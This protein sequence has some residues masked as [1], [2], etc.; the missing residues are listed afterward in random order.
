MRG[1]L[2]PDGSQAVVLAPTGAQQA[3][4]R[5]VPEQSVLEQEL[6]R[7]GERRPLALVDDL[8]RAQPVEDIAGRGGVIV[9][10]ADETGHG[11]VPEHAADDGGALRERPLLRWKRV[12]ACLQHTLQRR[13]HSRRA[14]RIVR[15]VPARAFRADDSLFDEPLEQ[16]LDVERVALG[17]AH[18]ELDQLGRNVVGALE[19]LRDEL[20]ALALRHRLEPDPPVVRDPSPQW[21]WCSSSTGRAVATITTGPGRESVRG[22][23]DQRQRKIIGPVQ[24]L[25]QD[26]NGGLLGE[27]GEV[28][29]E[30]RSPPLSQRLRVL[31]E[32]AG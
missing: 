15:D 3:L 16:L 32:F 25:Q 6:A 17:A 28:P 13:R 4:V 14:H 30:R 8:P 19:D 31:R 27:R 10:P 1:V 24:V 20:C 5:D 21:G 18:H 11:V 26:E 9:V 12:E 22:F 29:G 2:Q 7:V 23:V